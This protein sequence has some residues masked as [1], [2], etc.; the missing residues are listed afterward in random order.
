[1]ASFAIDYAAAL[2]RCTQYIYIYIYRC[3]KILCDISS[4]PIFLLCV[5]PVAA[6]D[7]APKTLPRTLPRRLQKPS[8]LH[9]YATE[10]P[11]EGL[12]K[13]TRAGTRHPRSS[14]RRT[15]GTIRHRSNPN[16][17]TPSDT[18][19]ETQASLRTTK[20]P[21]GPKLTGHRANRRQA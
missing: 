17:S 21:N 3:L 7:E 15:P 2:M 14:S 16:T 5:L 12:E 8:G 11:P 6:L 19:R 9:R 20:S 13:P 4:T 1:M 10:D 18:D